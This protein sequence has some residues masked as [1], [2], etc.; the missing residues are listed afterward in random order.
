MGK[1]VI[2]FS[3]RCKK[4]LLVQNVRH[5]SISNYFDSDE[6]LL[7]QPRN[8]VFVT[9]SK[10]TRYVLRTV[11]ESMNYAFLLIWRNFGKTGILQS[12]QCY[13]IL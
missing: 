7:F 6:K 12:F 9:N 1:S 10:T 4:K 11:V 2:N 13:L 3:F 5:H 8:S